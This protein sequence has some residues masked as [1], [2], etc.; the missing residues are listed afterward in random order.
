MY[1]CVSDRPHNTHHQGS[2]QTFRTRHCLT[3][4]EVK[5]KLKMALPDGEKKWVRGQ[6]KKHVE[7]DD[8]QTKILAAHTAMHNV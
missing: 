4:A 5:H 6:N 8:V 7:S 2:K 3:E 1:V